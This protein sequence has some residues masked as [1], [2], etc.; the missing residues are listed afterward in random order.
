MLSVTAEGGRQV[1]MWWDGMH[2][3][4]PGWADVGVV[5]GAHDLSWE[6][7]WCCWCLFVFVRCAILE[8]QPP[9]VI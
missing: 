2:R 3:V 5:L 7:P 6:L 8:L 1:G 4:F 9:L